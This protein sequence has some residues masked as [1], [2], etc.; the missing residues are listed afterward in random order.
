MCAGLPL[1]HDRNSL[2]GP[3]AILT[4]TEGSADFEAIVVLPGNVFIKTSPA[5]LNPS[6]HARVK[7]MKLLD[8]RDLFDCS[9]WYC[10]FEGKYVTFTLR[11][12]DSSWI[13][14][15]SDVGEYLETGGEEDRSFW[16]IT[17][18]EEGYV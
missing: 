1:Q 10:R 12:A 18:D 15:P 5:E 8:D 4:K 3:Y 7:S 17:G 2:Y 14:V 9:K 11:D 6:P 16:E 13:N